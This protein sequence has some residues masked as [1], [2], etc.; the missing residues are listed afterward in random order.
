MFFVVFLMHIACTDSDK[1]T[2]SLDT[3]EMVDSNDSGLVDEDGDG[4]SVEEGDCDDNNAMIPGPELCDGADNDCDGDIDESDAE[5]ATIWYEDSDGDGFGQ[6]N[7]SQVSCTQPD[8]FVS[9]SDDC[10]DEDAS[11]SP[12]TTEL[13]YDGIDSNCDGFSDYDQDGDGQDSDQYGGIDCDDLSSTVYVGATEIWYD[14]IDSDCDD[15]SDYD[16]DGDGQDSDQY[17]GMDC[18]DLSST[19]YVGATE[20]WYDG[21]DSDCDGLSDYDQDGDGEEL[22]S[23][24]GT[25]CDD[26]DSAINTSASEIWYDGIDQ[27][28]DFLDDYDS[29]GDGFDDRIVDSTNTPQFLMELH[30]IG[31]NADNALQGLAIDVEQDEIWMSVD[32]SFLFENVLINRLSLQ[33][34]NPQYCEE[35]KE[36]NN[37]GLGHGQDLSIEYSANGERLLWIGSESDRGVTRVDTDSMSIEVLSDLLP[38]GWSHSTP[39][40]GLKNEWI[41]VRGSKDGDESNNDWIRIYEKSEVESGFSTGQ[42]PSP[43]YSFNLVPQQRVGDMWFQGLALDEEVGVVYAFTGNSSLSQVDK[44]LYVYDLSGNVITHTTINMDWSTANSMGSKYEPEGL[45]LVQEANSHVRYLYFTMMFGSSGN[46]IKRLYSLAPSSIS[47]GGAYSNNDIDWLIRYNTTSGV[48]SIST[49]LDDGTLG[50]ETKRS[51]WSHGW[52]SFVGY[53]VDGDP[54]MLLQKEVG[55][56]TRIHSLDWDGTLDSLTKDSTWSDGWSDFQ[57]WEH[58]GSTYLFYYKSGGSYS[59]LM[60]TTELTSN[61]NTDCCFEDEYWSTGWNTHIYTLPNGD[62]FL[63][64]YLPSSQNVRLAPLT[65]GYIGTDVFNGTWTSDYTEFGSVQKDATTYVVALDGTGVLDCFLAEIN[66]ELTAIDTTM[67]V[68]SDWSSMMAYNLEGRAFVHLYRESDGFYTLYELDENGLFQ[69]PVESGFEEMGW[70][71]IHHFRTTP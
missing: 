49:A 29:D 33:S 17:G 38:A 70:T 9:S 16:Q 11:I 55:G 45:S 26:N 40:I 14:G 63:L 30:P 50:C 64:R 54:H 56:T 36:G 65:S 15:V 19:V 71:S 59:G 68:L 42:A 34:G 43:I 28:C 35:Y 6:T 10:D 67:T 12:N 62:D 60:K 46:N 52:S 20:I 39:T 66:G 22:L 69:G 3:N 24:G 4:L 47:T 2:D 41:A 44:L 32:T 61:G 21:I 5:D 7:S 8:G 53:Y 25:D 37:I 1:T 13:W 18:D 27:N 31:R 58:G 51:V 23:S 57:S 48:V